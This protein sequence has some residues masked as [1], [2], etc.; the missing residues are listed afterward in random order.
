MSSSRVTRGTTSTPA[1]LLTGAGGAA[2][3]SFVKAV[4]GQPLA[5]HMADMDPFAAGLYLVDA[6]RRHRLLPGAD[7]RFADHLL[8][9]CRRHAIDVL[10]PTV[11]VELLPI[12][13]ARE[14]FAAAGVRLLLA[15][16][17]AL[18]TCLDKLALL[19]AC[20]GVV[21]VGRYAQ[22][23]EAFSGEGWSLPFI[24]KPRGGSGSRDIQTITSAAA[25]AR[26]PR[27][28]RMLAQEWLPGDEYS[29]DVLVSSDGRQIAAVPRVRMKIDS[30]IAV[31]AK[32]IHDAELEALARRVAVRVG[33]RYTA[34][35]QFRRGAGG[36]PTLLEVNPRFPGTMPLTVHA[37]VNMPLLA[38]RDALGTAPP[39]GPLPFR[40]VAV[41]R[42]W[43]EA[44]IEPAEIDALA[45]ETARP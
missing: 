10:V 21:P 26:V 31:T 34:N 18:T 9:I 15:P 5:L 4:R 19:D 6:G 3:V 14:R 33:L 43:T 16:E 17:A 41:V 24:V 29:V 45:M 22:I 1:V 23:D 27:T 11:D 42:Y 8:D 44:F 28:G 7:A 25:L 40:D 13:R 30:G 37:G 36:T 12:V 2:A 32:T 38:L 20:D 35:I 39:D